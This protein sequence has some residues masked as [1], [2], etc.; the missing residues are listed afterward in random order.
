[1]AATRP[2]G[3]RRLA[4]TDSL[5]TGKEAQLADV[6][7]ITSPVVGRGKFVL[8]NL[9][10]RIMPLPP[11]FCPSFFNLPAQI[12]AEEEWCWRVAYV[13]CWIVNA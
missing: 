10:L 12:A 2:Q 8:A 1:L 5:Q 7:R 9:I 6:L 3:R 4:L 11:A 13:T